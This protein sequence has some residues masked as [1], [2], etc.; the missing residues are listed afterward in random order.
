MSLSEEKIGFDFSLLK[1]I[2]IDEMSFDDVKRILCMI[3]EHG[4]VFDAGKAKEIG[5]QQ[6]KMLKDFEDLDISKE[7]RAKK[8]EYAKAVKEAQELTDQDTYQSLTSNPYLKHYFPKLQRIGNI[9]GHR[10]DSLLEARIMTSGPLS[11][12]DL[13]TQ[14]HQVPYLK[15]CTYTSDGLM[16]GTNICVEIKGILRDSEEARKYK[17]VCQ[18]NNLA[19]LF[20]FAK[21]GIECSFATPRKDGSRYTHEE[22]AERQ[23]KS[24]LNIEYTFEDE[25][26]EFFRSDRF[27]AFYNKNRIQHISEA[28]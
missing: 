15:N 22:W 16:P 9:D 7:S 12:L 3:K 5:S 14:R 4:I 13:H 21:R 10:V 26:D 2:N 8:L 1:D 11:K 20:I 19:I 17:E 6:R 28:A 27:K 18:Q 25:Q 23:I 24:G